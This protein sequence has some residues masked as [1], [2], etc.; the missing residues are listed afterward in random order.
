MA[1][2]QKSKQ[3]GITIKRN[4]FN[5]EIREFVPIRL[6]LGNLQKHHNYINA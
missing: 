1:L 3:V 6:L 2:L 5:I 4:S